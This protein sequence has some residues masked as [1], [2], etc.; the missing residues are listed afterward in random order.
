MA[1]ASYM[2]RLKWIDPSTIF[3]RWQK[4]ANEH[5]ESIERFVSSEQSHTGHADE[6][7]NSNTSISS[8]R[9]P[10]YETYWRDFEKFTYGWV[11]DEF[12]DWLK[13]N[14][15]LSATLFPSHWMSQS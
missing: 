9:V 13:S 14:L 1:D 6:H 2:G 12:A 15:A 4:V 3:E 10:V 11:N 5:K 7:G 8:G